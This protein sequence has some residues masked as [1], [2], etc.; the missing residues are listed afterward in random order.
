[1]KMSSHNLRIWHVS[2]MQLRS[3]HNNSSSLIIHK[4][5]SKHHKISCRDSKLSFEFVIHK[6]GLTRQNFKLINNF[7]HIVIS[8]LKI[9]TLQHS[10]GLINV[11]FNPTLAFNYF[12]AI[13]WAHCASF[14][15]IFIF[16]LS[17]ISRICKFDYFNSF[18]VSK[19]D[20]ISLIDI[21]DIFK[22]EL[23]LLFSWDKLLASLGF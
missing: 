2:R 5:C 19:L 22:L 18:S 20:S 6:A 9:W 15:A 4:E 23:K 21:P 7:Q 3:G 14:S 1:M 13:S 10:R 11:T 8:F 17:P 16:D 12:E